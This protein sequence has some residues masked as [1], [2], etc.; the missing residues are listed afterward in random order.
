M[1]PPRIGAGAAALLLGLLPAPVPAQA[2]PAP[3][4]TA[5]DEY[6]ARPDPSYAWELV[7]SLEGEGFTAHV[8]DLTSQT[9][10]DAEAVDRT[11]WKHWLVLTVPEGADRRTA[12]LYIGG[13]AN[14]GE[15]PEGPHARSAA[16]ARAAGVAVAELQM[17][18]NQPLVFEGDG[19][20]RWEDDLV[21]YTWKRALETGEERWA[22]RLPMVKAAVRA[23]DTVQALLSGL[24]ADALPVERFVVAG[25]SKRGWT[26][27]L[28]GAVDPRVAAIAPIVIDVLNVVPSMEHHFGAYGFWAPAVGDYVHHGITERRRDPAFARLMELVD[29]H[30]YRDRLGMPKLILNASGDEFFLPDSSR[31]YF[32]DLPGEKL[33]RYVPNAGHSLSGTDALETLSAFTRAV[34]GDAPRPRCTWKFQEDGSIRVESPD[35]PTAVRLWTATNPAARDF[36]MESLGPVWEARDLEPE[37]EGVWRA[38]LEAPAE[39]FRAGFVELSFDGRGGG[40]P[41]KLTTEVRVLPDV[42]PFAGAL[43]ETE[44]PASGGR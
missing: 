40:P 17:V 18:P 19:E 10:L 37:A 9:W 14:G 39:G 12:L 22:A 35:A 23:M 33:L 29:P 21:A 27:W 4:P 15:A 42:L 26:T 38:P 34:A 13:G 8:V 2:A 44:A 36:R 28:T 3:G 1:R 25:A 30:A 6:V 31:F 11:L 20:R 41:W 32:D 16:L 24:E 7:R 5:L 43:E